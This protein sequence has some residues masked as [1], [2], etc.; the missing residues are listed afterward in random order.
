MDRLRITGDCLN[1]AIN[2]AL[3]AL[4]LSRDRM[5]YKVVGCTKDTIIIE[6][7][8]KLEQSKF[9]KCPDCGREISR[10]AESCPH[11]GCPIEKTITCHRCGY[12]TDLTYKQIQDLGFSVICKNC[13]YEVRVSSP[14]DEAR[15]AW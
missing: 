1:N 13:D 14:E 8:E 12:D 4:H 5:S 6:A 11:C 3:E 7:W 15:W 10:K 9:R 2:S